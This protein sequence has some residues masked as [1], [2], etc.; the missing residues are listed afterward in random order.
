VDDPVYIGKHPG[1]HSI[2]DVL[3]QDPVHLTLPH[4]DLLSATRHE[5]EQTITGVADRP[6][7]AAF[8]ERDVGDRL[9]LGQPPPEDISYIL[10][11]LGGKEEAPSY[12]LLAIGTHD[13][14]ELGRVTIREVHRHGIGLGVGHGGDLLVLVVDRIRE[15]A[16]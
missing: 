3:V 11:R 9:L 14:V 2:C 15:P 10:Q 7:H 8:E 5:V 13:E 4:R 16:P 1:E 6:G 12:G